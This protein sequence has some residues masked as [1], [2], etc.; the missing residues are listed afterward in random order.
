MRAHNFGAGPCTLPLHVLEETR[1]EL[2]DFR[3]AGMSL[4]E[5]SH[6]SDTYDE[7]HQG[8]IDT[9]RRVAAVPDQ[10]HILFIQ[11][12]ASLQFGMVPMNLLDTG[13][14]A[15]YLL[16]GS[17]AKG[18]FEDADLVGDA[19]VAWDGSVGGF[20]AMPGEDE[21][22]VRPNTRYVHVTTNET[23][24]GIRLPALPNVGVPLAADMSSDYLTRPIDWDRFDVVYGGVQ[25]NLAPAGLSVVFLRDGAVS[26]TARQLPRYLRY[27]W[28]VTGNSLANTP[29]M[30]PIWV[31]G[32]VLADIEATGGIEALEDRTR[33]KAERLYRV[34]D[35]SDGFYRNP[36]E[37]RSRSHTNV[38]FRLDSPEL[39]AEF[40]EETLRN[41][42]I[43][44]KGHRSVGGLRASLYAALELESVVALAE[45]MEDFA[46]RHRS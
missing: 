27:E 41:N 42:M 46:V 35:E 32:K 23:I 5:M 29:P 39:E 10:L 31:M 40:L 16:T 25:K 30:F 34:I 2:V 17:W 8:T 12:G 43:G 44:M 11:G 28:H 22:E 37:Q 6:R 13:M 19:Y 38:V 7:V 36:V 45:L 26:E 20:T 14:Q 1:D 15:G 3:G 9:L 24:G 4:L 21:V 18:A 33:A